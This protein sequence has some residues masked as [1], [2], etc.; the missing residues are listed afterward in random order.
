VHASSYDVVNFFGGGGT[1]GMEGLSMDDDYLIELQREFETT[2]DYAAL[3]RLREA[4]DELGVCL[5]QSVRCH[6]ARDP[7]FPWKVT[8]YLRCEDCHYVLREEVKKVPVGTHASSGTASVYRPDW[9]Q[10]R[11]KLVRCLC[12][13]PKETGGRPY[14]GGSNIERGRGYISCAEGCEYCL[15]ECR[16]CALEFCQQHIIGHADE[17][18]NLG[19]QCVPY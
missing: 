2:Q 4:A 16:G 3:E 12:G 19:E 14:C 9:C 11:D 5:H 10:T 15:Q 18:G 1:L 6:W 7:L 17:E 13:R 8:Y